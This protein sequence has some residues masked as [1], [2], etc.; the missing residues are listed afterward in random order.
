MTIDIQR[1]NPLAP[2]LTREEAMDLFRRY[3]HVSEDEAKRLLHFLRKGRHLDV[4]MVI[5]DE[6]LKPQLDLFTADHS[7]QLSVGIGETSVLIAAI[8]AFLAACWFVWETIKPA[9]LTV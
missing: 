6:R 1:R 5:G 4:G 8:F 7:K 3:P 9:A 2:M